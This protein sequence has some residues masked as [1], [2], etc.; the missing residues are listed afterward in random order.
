MVSMVFI[1]MGYVDSQIKNL[2]SSPSHPL[3]LIL[4]PYY[5]NFLAPP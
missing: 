5:L 2:K 3:S 4:H 1:E